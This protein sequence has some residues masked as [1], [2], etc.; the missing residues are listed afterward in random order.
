[1]FSLFEILEDELQTKITIVD[2]GAASL[3]DEPDPYDAL[4][5]PGRLHLIGF[6]P[7]EE[8]CEL[9]KLNGFAC[10]LKQRNNC[11]WKWDQKNSTI[12]D[13]CSCF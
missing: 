1:M 7:V 12:E 13:P 5:K 3:G 11:I 2:V 8:Q 6:E 9:I 10:I 4:R